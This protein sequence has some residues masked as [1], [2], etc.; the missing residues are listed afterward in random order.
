[1][2]NREGRLPPGGGPAHDVDLP[3]EGLVANQLGRAALHDPLTDL[4]NRRGLQDAV[5]AA[6][7]G[8]VLLHAELVRI[9]PPAARKIP[10]CDEMVLLTIGVRLRDVIRTGDLPARVGPSDLAVLLHEPHDDVDQR[11][12]AVRAELDRPVE[13]DGVLV[14]MGAAIGTAVLEGDDDLDEVVQRARQRMHDGPNG[15][16]RPRQR[17]N[18]LY[19]PT[20]R[21]SRP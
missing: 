19:R 15:W 8:D 14:E 16:A 1:M 5:R 20:R 13:V 11:V 2:M 10:H 9:E 4:A 3:A 12:A 18:R 17:L 6:A 7:P 21:D